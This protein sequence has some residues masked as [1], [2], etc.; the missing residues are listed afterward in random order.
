[1]YANWMLCYL[2]QDKIIH[3]FRDIVVFVETLQ[4]ISRLGLHRRLSFDRQPRP[5]ILKFEQGRA[6]FD[7]VPSVFMVF[8]LASVLLHAP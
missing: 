5:P 1:M 3:D 2:I 7:N 4:P 8:L 6:A